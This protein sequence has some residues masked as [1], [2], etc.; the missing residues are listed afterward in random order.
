MPW[1]LWKGLGVEG[2]GRRGK[3]EEE[4]EKGVEEGGGRN[5]HTVVLKLVMC[6]K[7]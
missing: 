2:R 3:G 7:P 1:L 6:S 4:G 5:N